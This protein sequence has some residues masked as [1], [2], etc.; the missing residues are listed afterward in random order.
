VKLSIYILCG[1]NAKKKSKTRLKMAGH[2]ILDMVC[3][4]LLL[5]CTA[6]GGNVA[7]EPTLF[8]DELEYGAEHGAEH[9]EGCT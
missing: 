3:V 7:I 4:L 9:G 5:V 2:S 8:E 1:L 6:G